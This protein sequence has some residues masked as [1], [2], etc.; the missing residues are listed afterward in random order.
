[1]IET[2][3]NEYIRRAFGGEEF[4]CYVPIDKKVILQCEGSE[5]NESEA[6][7][8][9]Y[10]KIH[11]PMPGGAI[12]LSEGDIAFGFA[13]KNRTE[14][15]RKIVLGDIAAMLR[16]K[17]INAAENNNDVTVNGY[18]VVGYAQSVPSP[19]LCVAIAVSMNA[20]LEDIRAIC[21]KDMV[22]VPTG[23]SNYGITRQD[24]IDVFYNIENRVLG[25]SYK[26]YRQKL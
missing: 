5:I 16:S 17:G 23:L 14:D 4:F 11:I 25:K 26:I 12:V 7:R 19:L 15:Y 6:I 2:T 20:N 10:D 24:M 22:K 8:R 9:G 13:S 21:T 1:M 3:A 18:K